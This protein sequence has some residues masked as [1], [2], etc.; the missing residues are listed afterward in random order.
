MDKL[1]RYKILVRYIKNTGIAPSQKALGRLLGYSNE[2]YFSQIINGQ[3]PEP[4]DFGKK[5]LDLVPGLN[6][7]WLESGEGEMIV[8]DGTQ[9]APAVK[10]SVVVPAEL[11]Q[12]FSD[13]AATVRSQQ[14]TIRALVDARVEGI[15][16][17]GK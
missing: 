5:V 9:K 16:N 13:L 14:E 3:V 15:K 4:K 7:D 2:S 8:S 6:L 1:D 12:M 10:A 11:V 17:F